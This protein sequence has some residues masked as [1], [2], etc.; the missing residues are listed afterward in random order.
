MPA[1]LNSASHASASYNFVS[2]IYTK[3]LSTCCIPL[4]PQII[5]PLLAPQKLFIG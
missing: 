3:M 4:N 1:P 2:A 5:S